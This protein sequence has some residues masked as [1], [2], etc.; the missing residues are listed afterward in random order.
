[1]NLHRPGRRFLLLA[2]VLGSSA[3]LRAQVNSGSVAGYVV[4]PSGAAVSGVQIT[5]RN[6]RT[7]LDTTRATGAEGQYAFEA[8]PTG[9]YELAAEK[10]GFKT[11]T[12]TGIDLHIDQQLRVDLQLELGEVTET[13]T[14][15]AVAPP[16][17]TES[18]GTGE[19]ITANQIRDLPLLGRNAL[20]LLYL[21]P[22]VAAGAGGNAANY[23]VSGQR[24]FANSI[25]INGIEV[26]ANRNND[27]NV[28]PSVDSIE[29]FKAITSSYAA[30][31]GRAGGGV[32]TIET[33]S[34]SNAFHG[35][36]YEFLRTNKTTARNFFAQQPS[37]LKQNTF[38]GTLGGQLVRG[39]T[40]FFAGYQGQRQRDLFSYLT[41][42]VPNGVSFPGTG[43]ADLSGL[44]D[45]YT[46]GQ[47]PVFDPQFYNDNYYAQQFPGNVIPASRLS[48]AGVQVLQKLFP[49]PNAPGILNGWVNN[50]QVAQRYRFNSDTGDLRLD[51]SLSD[52]Q[53]LTATYDVTDF[54]SL[55]GDPFAGA[56]AIPGGGGADS[57]DRTAS[58]NHTLGGTHVFVVNGNQ[59][60][61]LRLGYVHTSLHQ[62]DL[63]A[64]GAAAQLGIGNIHVNGFPA[65]DGLPQIF[66]AFG[67]QTGGSTYKPLVFEDN[68]FSLADHYTWNHGRHSFKFGYEYRR[69]SANPSF[70]LF[71]AGYQYYYGAYAS[72]T[73]D[74]NYGYYDPNAYYG[75][76]GNE[77]A[78][79]LLGLP[80]YTAL[81]MQFLSPHTRSFEN[82][83][84]AQ[85]VWRVT[86]TLTI[87]L[88]VRYEYQAPYWEAHNYQANLDLGSF[89][90]RLAGRGGNSRALVRPDKNNWAPRVGLAWRIGEKTVIRSGY[91]IFYTPENSA[92]SD[93]LTKNDPFFS[94]QTFVNYAGGAFAYQ[95]DAGVPRPTSASVP[96]NTSAV[97]PSSPDQTL[98][99]VDP[100]F[101]TG[102]TQSFNFTVQR[103][104]G[105]QFTVEA[106]YVGALSHK[107]PM[108]TANLNLDGRLSDQIGTVRALLFNGN[109]AY[110]SLQVKASRRFTNLT[111]L[112]SYTYAKNL[113]NGPAPFN[114]MRNRQAPQDPFNLALE[115]GPA[116]TDVRHTLAASY[117]WKL[118]FGRG[119]RWLAGC[120]G[121]CQAALAGWQLNGIV[122]MRSGLP[123]NVIRNGGVVGY[124]GLRPNVSGDPNLDGSQRTLT[125]YF[126][127]S[128]FSTA[129][130]GATQPGT[131]G[132]NILR[133]PGFINADLSLFKEFP[134]REQTR[135][136]LRLE[137]FNATNTPHFANPET[138]FSQGQFGTITRTVG[139]PR[140]LQ[141]AA[142]LLF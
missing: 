60:N 113:D 91:G 122:N 17:Q 127:T 124:E 133:G 14:V 7:G 138:G 12:R 105:H 10:A 9:P 72:L 37:G 89:Q 56:I 75:N 55:T 6:L 16:L 81:G 94:Q 41:S 64:P 50:Y 54:R 123:V 128:A 26:T 44:R 111:F 141:I 31:F 77:I 130:L 129:G 40:F 2:V 87:D 135:L 51:H 13:V 79:L 136:Q 29:E 78:D 30:E 1:M 61:Q 33:R 137:A 120:R 25:V 108:A 49:R 42:T 97:A 95:L 92:R 39:R 65:T 115:R 82:H 58:G 104:L 83:A 71:P 106:G 24:E 59:L 88:G 36:A 18:A 140:I 101:R 139:N 3:V 86:S 90:M 8:L 57:A 52:R 99:Y 103:E 73:G 93:L 131:A 84:F 114:L 116:S 23:S 76:G 125:R 69:L 53:R 46:G 142:K 27:T 100:H 118:P 4:D 19:V 5:L 38:G 74:P 63:I 80:G 43:G 107:L 66:L 32:V 35:V 110:H 20:D 134:L 22:G 102:Y 126:D 28:R 119:Q 117:E 48:P 62:D 45:P 121:V 85:D 70:P 47:I 96:A 98:Y 112:V 132:R 34:G 21:I 109:S 15:T 11:L 68:N 67:A